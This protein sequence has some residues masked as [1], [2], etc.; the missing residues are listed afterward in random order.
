MKRFLDDWLPRLFP[1]WV[2]AQ[3]FLCVAH[4]GKSDLDKSMPQKLRARWHPEDR[5]VIVRDN[6]GA[7]CINL[8][9]KLRAICVQ[10]GRPKALIRL[11]CQELES[12]Y[13]G[14]LKALAVAFN[15]LKLDT[16]KLRKRFANPDEWKKPSKEIE[17]LVPSFNKYSGACCMAQ[18]LDSATNR[19]HS[20]KMFVS[21]VRRLA[22]DMGLLRI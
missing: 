13:L 18:Y 3:H 21:G 10:N 20:L 8:K 14:D 12:W 16:P 11:V 7:D 15:Q 4:Q 6:D 5:F 9:N 22:T 1:G 2:P 19:S 17:R